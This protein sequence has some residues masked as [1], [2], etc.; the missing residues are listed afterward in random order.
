MAVSTLL[1]ISRAPTVPATIASV[2]KEPSTVITRAD[3]VS[4]QF[5]HEQKNHCIVFVVITFSHRKEILLW[6]H[7]G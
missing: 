6:K 1:P 2:R 4:G 5:D 7:R 3:T